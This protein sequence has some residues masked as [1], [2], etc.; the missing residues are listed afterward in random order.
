MHIKCHI[1]LERIQ[2]VRITIFTNNKNEY[3]DNLQ[4]NGIFRKFSMSLSTF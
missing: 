2:K 1:I 3:S 4:E